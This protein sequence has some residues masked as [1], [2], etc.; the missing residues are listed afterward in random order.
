MGTEKAFVRL[1]GRY[2][3]EHALE[4]ARSITPQVMIVG[5]PTKFSRFA[6]VVKDTFRDRGPLGGIH[7]ALAATTT[8]WNLVI[9]VD[10][11]FVTSA[12]LRF[13]SG[14][15][16]QSE[17]VTPLVVVPRADGRFQPLCA[18]YRK[19]FRIPAEKALERGE[20][21]IDS[22][23]QN[24]GIVIVDE[25]EIIHAGFSTEIFRNLNTP[26]DLAAAEA[27]S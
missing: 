15:C 7:A 8:D 12:F 2:L 26:E 14:R 11:P 4:A 9:A 5:E 6:P 20:N 21:K 19:P 16:P 27:L 1:K 13:L 10:L 25:N 18:L 22:L 3:L 23:F 24:S 17:N